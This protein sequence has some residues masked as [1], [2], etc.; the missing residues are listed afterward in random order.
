MEVMVSSSPLVSA[1]PSS[2]GEE[3]SALGPCSAVGCLP[4]ETVLHQL[5]QRGSFPQAAVPQKLPWRGS[6]PR[7]YLQSQPV[8]VWAF[9]WSGGH[10]GGL[11]SPAPLHGL[12]GT[13]CRLTAGCGG[14]PSCLPP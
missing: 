9:P 12:G 14:I 4:Q 13:A 11:R 10:L 3:D 5:L 8:L 2:S 7:A 6:F 1:A